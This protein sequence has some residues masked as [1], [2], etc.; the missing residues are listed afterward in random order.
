MRPWRIHGSG[1]PAWEVRDAV[2]YY[3]AQRDGLG[4]EFL[5]EFEAAVGRIRRMPE[6][7]P[8]IGQ[9]GMRKHRLHRFLGYTIYYASSPDEVW[10]V[11]V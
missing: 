10:I 1:R 8:S 2:E 3:N 7:Y 6:A 4:T 5:A 11:A 9:R